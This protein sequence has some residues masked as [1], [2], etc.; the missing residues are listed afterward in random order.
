MIIGP[1]VSLS[2]YIKLNLSQNSDCV[3]SSAV[4]GSVSFLITVPILSSYLGGGG[5]VTISRC[6]HNN[7]NIFY[8]LKSQIL[9]LDTLL[10]SLFQLRS[11][12]P[13]CRWTNTV[14]FFFLNNK[15][16]W[17]SYSHLKHS[18]QKFAMLSFLYF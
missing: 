13:L 14:F 9:N 16:V 3:P 17:S 18:V 12:E 4:F 1:V 5:S 2:L 11:L 6:S 7:R 8:F 10:P 15:D